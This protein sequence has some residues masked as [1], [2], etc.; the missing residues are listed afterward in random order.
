MAIFNA[1]SSTKA[2]AR[3]QP[4]SRNAIA[5]SGSGWRSAPLV[6]CGI[7]TPVGSCTVKSCILTFRKFV[8]LITF[9]TL[10]PVK[11]RCVINEQLSLALLVDIVSFEEDIDRAVEAVSVRDTR[12][13]DPSLV[14]EHF[15]GER[16]Q[17]LIDLQ[18]RTAS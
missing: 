9:P 6:A 2:G 18:C 7:N 10:E 11:S 1:I 5:S 16:Q 3:Q 15:D 14:A 4:A 8:G 13:V 17:F 12:T